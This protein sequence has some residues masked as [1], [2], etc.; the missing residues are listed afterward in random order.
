MKITI[1]S[2]YRVAFTTAL[3]I[4]RLIECGRFAEAFDVIQF[5]E[6]A[7]ASS[8]KWGTD[9]E[10]RREILQRCE[11]TLI[12]GGFKPDAQQIEVI[13]GLA[14]Y[15]KVPD[16]PTYAME[17]DDNQCA[18]LVRA[19]ESYQRLALGQVDE[20]LEYFCIYRKLDARERDLDVLNEMRHLA[21]RSGGSSFGITNFLLPDDVRNGRQAQKVLEHHLAHKRNPNGGVTQRF[22]NPLRMRVGSCTAQDISI[23]DPEFMPRAKNDGSLS[24]GPRF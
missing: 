23:Y 20:P 4:A 17:V 3:S 5:S 9:L 11:N 12:I 19:L 21:T 2:D 7:K 24:S 10:R 16:Q 1:P 22:D 8:L 15:F 18:V 13:D 6:E 14:S